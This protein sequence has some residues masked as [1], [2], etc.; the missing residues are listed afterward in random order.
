M[1]PPARDADLADGTDVGSDTPYHDLRTA[2]KAWAST[3]GN[4]S[5]GWPK[6]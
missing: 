3:V 1:S 2:A 6:S 4:S 5:S